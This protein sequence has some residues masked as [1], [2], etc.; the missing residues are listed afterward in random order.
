MRD[1]GRIK[2]RIE[3][4]LDTRQVVSI[5]L[6]AAVLM[7]IVFYLGVTVGKDLGVG[8]APPRDPLERLDRMA[9]APGSEITFPDDL[10]REDENAVALA[11][12]RERATADRRAAEV[13]AGE[14]AAAEA[15]AAEKARAEQATA[16]RAAADDTEARLAAAEKAAADIAADVAAG[17][18]R[19]AKGASTDLSAALA[20]GSAQRKE[21][22]K[23]DKATSAG[24]VR[25][26]VQ[27]A[28]LPD[29]KEAEAFA[30]RLRQQG[31]APIVTAA[32]IPGKGTF[33]RVRL[34]RFDSR[35]E[36]L[37]YLDDVR[38]ET[39]LE[40]FVAAMEG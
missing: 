31:L 4:T 27:V 22:P 21:S 17:K 34:G 28:S 40:G 11:A 23:E 35:D 19:A 12:A 1:D 38:R 10:I 33:Y 8:E 36:A 6:G 24:G 15:A 32:E 37:R 30:S 20:S 16:E 9:A 5:V 18:P 14:K 13:A 39:R 26:T 3:L 2:E 25:F 7:G 29:R